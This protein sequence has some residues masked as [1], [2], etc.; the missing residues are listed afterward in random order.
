MSTKMHKEISFFPLIEEESINLSHKTEFKQQ[1]KASS[2]TQ[3]TVIFKFQDKEIQLR[4]PLQNKTKQQLINHLLNYSHNILNKSRQISLLPLL[5]RTK[6]TQVCLLSTKK[7]RFQI[8]ME[9]VVL[10]LSKRLISLLSLHIKWTICPSI[11]LTALLLNS[12]KQSAK[13]CPIQLLTSVK[14]LNVRKDQP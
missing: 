13:F 10:S 11:K 3:G 2:Q 14:I 9:T 7:Q 1:E 12:I 5:N 6:W 8:I 4:D